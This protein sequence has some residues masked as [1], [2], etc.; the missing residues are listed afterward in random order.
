VFHGVPGVP[1][2]KMECIAG[3]Y[4]MAGIP[5]KGLHHYEPAKSV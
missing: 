3:V 1:R 2:A 4:P 5:L